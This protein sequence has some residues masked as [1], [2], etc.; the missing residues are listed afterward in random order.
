MASVATKV[1]PHVLWKTPGQQPNGLQA[2]DDGLWVID[3][4]DPND[5]YLLRWQ[6]GGELRRFPTR[7][8]HSSG[9]TIDPDGHIWVGAT[10]SYQIICFDSETGVELK[11]FPTPPYDRSGGA[12]GVEWRDGR[13]W[14]SVPVARQIFVMDPSTGR[15]ERSIPLQGDRAH[16]IAWDPQDGHIWSVDSNRRVIYK[17]DP[18]SGQIKDAVGLSGPEPHGLTIWGGQFWLCDAESRE[19]YTVPL[20]P[21]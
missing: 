21:P 15:I 7:A 3:Q 2:T 9:I 18:D 4:I 12:H 17:L 14:F 19:V 8:L 10:F 5:I 16:G 11:A 13:L 6:D 20:P 1:E